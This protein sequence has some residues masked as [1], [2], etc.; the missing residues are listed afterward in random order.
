MAND[1]IQFRING[2]LKED[3]EKVYAELGIDLPTAIRIFLTRSVKEQG[4]PFS[5]KLFA[6]ED[7]NEFRAEHEGRR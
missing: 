4:L 6:E 7:A 1:L 5:M 2:K 3:A